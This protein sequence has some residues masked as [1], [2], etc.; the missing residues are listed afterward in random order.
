ME[1][2]DVAPAAARRVCVDRPYIAPTSDAH[3]LRTILLQPVSRGAVSFEAL[4]T[5]GS[6]N[7]VPYG[8][9]R[10]E[11]DGDQRGGRRFERTSARG[12]VAGTRRRA[13]ASLLAA[14]EARKAR[15]FADGEVTVLTRGDM[16]IASVTSN[17]NN[18][19]LERERG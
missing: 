14:W 17:P 7:V 15:A 13:G 11:G 18:L 12:R 10:A 9:S 16:V 19:R 6:C 4:M 2:S 1:E 3:F 8:V 5:R